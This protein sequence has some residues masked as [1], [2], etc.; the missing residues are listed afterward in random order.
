MF[1]MKISYHTLF[2]QTCYFSPLRQQKKK[3]KKRKKKKKE[4]Y[5][6][7]TALLLLLFKMNPRKFDELLSVVGLRTTTSSFRNPI[8]VQERLAITLRFL[9]SGDPMTS[10]CYLLENQQFKK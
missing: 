3:E 4:N 10:I 8:S 5:W 7:K 9:T 1:F 6:R 2:H